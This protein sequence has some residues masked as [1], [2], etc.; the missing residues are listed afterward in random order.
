MYAQMNL[1][2]PP[3]LCL[4]ALQCWDRQQHL[5]DEQVEDRLKDTVYDYAY[6]EGN[7]VIRTMNTTYVRMHS[8]PATNSAC[9]HTIGDY[10]G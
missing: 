9:N 2:M 3:G 10:K 5:I 4:L 8:V 6:Q 7:Y 1:R